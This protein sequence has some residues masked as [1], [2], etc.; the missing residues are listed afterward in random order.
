ME[1][2][3]EVIFINCEIIMMHVHS[4]LRNLGD[5][6]IYEAFKHQELTIISLSS[7]SNVEVVI[8]RRWK[9]VWINLIACE[10]SLRN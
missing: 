1:K 2:G 6:A 8:K 4:C 10:E 3:K 5:K 9:Q 7:S